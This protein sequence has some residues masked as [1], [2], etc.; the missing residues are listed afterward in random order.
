MKERNKPIT[1]LLLRLQGMDVSKYDDIFLNKILQKRIA[2][3]H[4]ESEKDYYTLLTQNSKEIKL[5]GDSLQI[6]YSEFFRNSLSFAVLEHILLPSLASR[7]LKNK[8]KEIRIWSAA[9]ASGQEAYSLAI[10]LEEFK[11]NYSEA[12]N[13][14]IFATDQSETQLSIARIGQYEKSA[15]NFMTMKRI[16]QWFIKQGNIY[17]IKPELKEK[18]DFSFFDL[19]NEQIASPS[20]SIYGDFDL[21]VS[22]NLLFYYKPEYRKIILNK[23]SNALDEDGFLVCGETERDICM[24]YNLKE[25]FPHSA[26]FSKDLFHKAFKL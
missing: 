26:I 2:E 10:L 1:E 9:C 8:S 5:F 22:A 24:K 3:T 19:L 4:C 7:K 23:I 13:Y 12:F 15:L 20:V 25:I 21:V 11:Q 18:I 14:R 17:S 16:N 6:S